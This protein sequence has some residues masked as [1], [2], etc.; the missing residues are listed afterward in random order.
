MVKSCVCPA[1]LFLLQFPKTR[2]NPFILFKE[3]L[4][5]HFCRNKSPGGDQQRSFRRFNQNDSHLNQSNL[6]VN[7]HDGHFNQDDLNLNW[8]NLNFNQ[9]NLSLNRIN[10]HFNQGNLSLNRIN[11]NFN[12]GDLSV[13]QDDLNVLLCRERKDISVYCTIQCM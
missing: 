11:L 2:A 13:H 12:Q 7:Q 3:R 4:P 6:N 8:V 1:V 5:S 10:S 9:G